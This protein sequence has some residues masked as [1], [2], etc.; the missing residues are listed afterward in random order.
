LGAT[1]VIK[2]SYPA[3]PL[4]GVLAVVRRDNRVLLVQ[5]ANPP[6]QGLW[7]FPGGLQ[8][9]GETLAAA[10][11]RELREETGVTAR[12]IGPLTALDAIQHDAS[13]RVEY[14]FTLVAILLEWISGEGVADDDAAA[15]Q[16]LAMAE[17]DPEKLPLIR[18]VAD[19]ARL[20][21]K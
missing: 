19:V 18:N 7:G 15:V 9:V 1:I 8:D 21:L 4:V 14:H 6:N 17:M 13:N 2:R 10:A 20:A 3:H 12:A 16:W 5:R 11:V